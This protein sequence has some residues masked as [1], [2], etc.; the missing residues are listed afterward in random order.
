MKPELL[1]VRAVNQYRRRD[2]LAY[3][4]LRY[5]LE[6]KST[7]SDRWA[8]EVSTHLV[9][10]RD[11]PIYF[12]SYHYK[13]IGEGDSVVHRNIYIPGPNEILAESTLLQECS[14]SSSFSTLP[15]VYS[16]KFPA[17][18]NKE[19]VFR[20]YFP[21]FKERHVSIA[22]AF[23]NTDGAMVRYADIRK[24]YPNIS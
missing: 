14:L 10:T 9:N 5:Y 15:C 8:R 19:G 1:S 17:K 21:G 22:K 3:I 12:R 20:S 13:E 23:A 6:S 4:G 16:Y 2:I 11:A 7:Q 24:F 18:N